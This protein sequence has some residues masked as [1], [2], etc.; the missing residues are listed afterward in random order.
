MVA[1]LDVSDGVITIIVNHVLARSS[2]TISNLNPGGDSAVIDV[3]G[4]G[5]ARH[6]GGKNEDRLKHLNYICDIF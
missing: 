1:D 6:D 2:Y 3:S 5:N 4:I